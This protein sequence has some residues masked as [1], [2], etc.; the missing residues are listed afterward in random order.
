MK[1]VAIIQARMNSSRFYGKVMMDVA[2]K[3]MLQRIVE[4]V[5]RSAVDQV[6]VAT[7]T[8]SDDDVIWAFCEDHHI[9]RFRG[10]EQDVL[11]RYYRCAKSFA[12]QVIVR[13]TA[14]C[15]LIDPEIIDDCLKARGESPYC[16]NI[17]PSRS[18]PDGLDVEVFTLG[19]LDD[20][21][22]HAREL[23]AR[24]HV[25]LWMQENA[26]GK[27]PPIVNLTTQ[28]NLSHLRWTVDT[29][30]DLPFILHVYQELSGPFSWKEVLA[31][32]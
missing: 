3:P 22:R 15:P 16:S 26:V 20:A 27:P 31:L 25:T 7:S 19:C 13:I 12:A 24:E 23:N 30:E 32:E 4:R 28:P 29:P 11:Q 17:F 14:D 18:Y 1:T 8:A 2:G 5:R 6:I 10:D 21:E 9:A